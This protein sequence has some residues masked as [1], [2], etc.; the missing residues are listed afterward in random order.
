MRAILRV[1]SVVC[2]CC[3]APVAAW[4][5][6]D[7]RSNE[8]T[9]G[10]TLNGFAGVATDSSQNGAVLGGAVGWELTP[11]LAIEGSGS[12][13]EFGHGANAFG[14]AVKVRTRL[15]GRRTVDPFL[16]AGIGMYRA[17][18]VR[19]EESVPTFYRRRMPA[20]MSVAGV[21]VSFS[22]PTLV[23]GGGVNIFVNRHFAIRPDLEAT[24]VLRDRR[25]HVVTS[26]ALHAVYHFESHPVTPVVKR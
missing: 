10:T 21:G 4:A 9:R 5:Q 3:A 14:G 25:H 8:W 24:F 17:S 2:V 11:R 1:V 7:I 12:W 22:D 23:A 19:G 13:L 20:H 18:F 26:V 16:Q 15:S 6:A